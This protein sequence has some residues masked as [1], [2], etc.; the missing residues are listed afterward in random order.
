M[1]KCSCGNKATLTAILCYH[2]MKP[3]VDGAILDITYVCDDH[4]DTYTAK[5][6]FGRDSFLLAGVNTKDQV[7]NYYAGYYD[8]EIEFF[9]G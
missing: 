5:D 8:S 3:N 7:E 2:D 4:S 1:T 9:M 6:C